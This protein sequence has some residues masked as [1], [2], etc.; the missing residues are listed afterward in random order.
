M[1]GQ[2]AIVTDECSF[3]LYL[4]VQRRC[5]AA[6]SRD[7]CE[8]VFA[9]LCRFCMFGVLLS[10]E[11]VRYGVASAGGPESHEMLKQ[12]GEQRMHY[13]PAHTWSFSDAAMG[14]PSLGVS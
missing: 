14:N 6:W 12:R 5:I 1:E 2:F 8:L 4:V 10:T 9:G 7:S 11:E 3:A 13:A